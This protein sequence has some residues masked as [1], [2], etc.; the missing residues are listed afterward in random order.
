M[1][2]KC[3]LHFQNLISKCIECDK[4]FC[5]KCLE[6]KINNTCIKLNH[7]LKY[8]ENKN[9]E[10]KGEIHL[11]SPKTLFSKE[12]NELKDYLEKAIKFRN[13]FEQDYSLVLNSLKISFN[14]SMENLRKKFQKLSLDMNL[15]IQALMQSENNLKVLQI[16]MNDLDKLPFYDQDKTEQVN[17]LIRNLKNNHKNIKEKFEYYKNNKHKIK[18]QLNES[19]FSISQNISNVF[20]DSKSYKTLAFS[21][22]QSL[23]MLK[24]N[25]KKDEYFAPKTI[26][27]A[28]KKARNGEAKYS[29]YNII[30]RTI[31]FIVFIIKYFQIN[32]KR[33]GPKKMNIY[34]L[35]SSIIRFKT[36]LGNL[37]IHLINQHNLRMKENN[38]NFQK[39]IN[40]IRINHNLVKFCKIIVSKHL[41]KENNIS[42]LNN[43]EISKS[44]GLHSYFQNKFNWITEKHL[45]KK[46]SDYQK[47][48]KINLSTSLNFGEKEGVNSPFLFYLEL[49]LPMNIHIR[50]LVLKKNIKIASYE[51]KYVIDVEQH[52]SFII[53]CGGYNKEEDKYLK[54]CSGF[55]LKN[56]PKG[57]MVTLSSLIEGRDYHSLVTTPIDLFLIAGYNGKDM[58]LCEC[59]N[60]QK[61]ELHQIS[62]LNIYDCCI[63]SSFITPK[64][65]YTFG[66]WK[67]NAKIEVLDISKPQS[68]WEFIEIEN[69]S[70]RR[71]GC[72]IQFNN[73]VW[74]LGGDC[75]PLNINEFN[76][77]TKNVSKTEMKF[78]SYRYFGSKMRI[79]N[80][81]AHIVGNSESIKLIEINLE[82]K[83]ISDTKISF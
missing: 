52:K 35:K 80:K 39:K 57:Q 60:L 6:E 83:K 54:N 41:L 20:E 78:N 36:R 64:F 4:S 12:R 55:D 17:N 1:S 40:L 22:I 33:M 25:L 8:F 11:K 81:N 19:T 77:E 24:N 58:N 14:K 37:I 56:F 15:Y 62:P 43:Q 3:E 49:G 7:N 53:I 31:I 76:L 5:E 82:T 44:K 9:P 10:I 51:N 29:S 34:T 26:K 48:S 68:Q 74:L 47:A 66:G 73:S 75:A 30:I 27:E 45:I 79:G 38:F 70:H 65:I 21:S 13:A 50:N 23:L 67:V 32:R 61:N 42:F 72:S 16:K 69:F 59:F 71:Y 28:L 63:T 18:S 46:K 2:K